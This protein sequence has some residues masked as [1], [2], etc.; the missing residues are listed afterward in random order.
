MQHLKIGRHEHRIGNIEQH[1]L[2]AVRVNSH[3]LGHFRILFF[4]RVNA[5]RRVQVE[6][7]AQP[8]RV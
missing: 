1:R 6:R 2:L 8:A 4:V 3:A 5:F 7:R